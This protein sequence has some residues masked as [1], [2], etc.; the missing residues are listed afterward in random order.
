MRRFANRDAFASYNLRFGHKYGESY[1]AKGAP[2]RAWSDIAK[3]GRRATGRT[4][5][6]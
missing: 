3:I 1:R 4:V 5:T 2:I 6:P